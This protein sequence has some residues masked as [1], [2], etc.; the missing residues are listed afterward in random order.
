MDQRNLTLNCVWTL[1]RAVSLFEKLKVDKSALGNAEQPEQVRENKINVGV[2]SMHVWQATL[3]GA[4]LADF[5][6]GH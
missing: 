6:V 4:V 3:G 1:I 2:W 5:Q